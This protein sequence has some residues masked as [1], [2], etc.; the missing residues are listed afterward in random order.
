MSIPPGERIR[1]RGELPF[2]DY[3]VSHTGS[4]FPWS[5]QNVP[6]EEVFDIVVPNA[7]RILLSGGVINNPFHTVVKF[8]SDTPGTYGGTKDS[9]T[10]SWQNFPT[11][12]YM[13]GT[14]TGPDLPAF[15][16][17]SEDRSRLIALAKQ[18]AI[19]KIDSTDFQFG[20]DM[21][22]I[23]KTYEM[24]R[25]P[26]GVMRQSHD[27]LVSGMNELMSSR[28]DAS[29][30][31]SGIAQL[32]LG[33]Q[34]A[35]GSF[36]HT[37]ANIYSKTNYFDKINRLRVHVN[38]KKRAT[39]E[40]SSHGSSDGMTT[41]IRGGT[42][43]I[44][45]QQQGQ[46]S[47][48][49]KAGILYTAGPRKRYN[50]VGHDWGLRLKDLPRAAWAVTPLTWF[51]DRFYNIGAGITGFMNLYDP[52]I[53]VL[54][55]WLVE[56]EEYENKYFITSFTDPGWT[57]NYSGERNDH[58]KSIYRSVWSPSFYDLAPT[59]DMSSLQDIKQS[60][61][62]VAMDLGRF[63]AFHDSRGR[64]PLMASFGLLP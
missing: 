11:A 21:F 9:T 31:S 60:L 63:R 12:G 6:F 19:E 64:N 18:K 8:N 59:L 27:K 23:K 44:T 1:N 25:D 38:K 52:K 48:K 33:S 2:L 29:K 47:Y 20:E 24:L 36:L 30:L 43:S 49:A 58:E 13:Y 57:I 53:N 55:A 45:F 28:H 51:S 5:R 10:F 61:D 54:T 46:F 37:A 42:Q 62:A 34:F 15:R 35:Y 22:E 40:F 4:T 39:A 56:V 17:S 16:V 32:W 14:S 3:G 41:R 50:S 7:R 26:L